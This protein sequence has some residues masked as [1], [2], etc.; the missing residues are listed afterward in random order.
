MTR[1]GRI[2]IWIVVAIAVLL[3]AIVL[4]VALFN[5]N[6]ARPW[7]ASDFASKQSARVSSNCPTAGRSAASSNGVTAFSP[8]SNSNCCNFRRGM[9]AAARDDVARC[10]GLDTAQRFRNRMRSGHYPKGY[11]NARTNDKTASEALLQHVG[12]S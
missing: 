1:A 9:R 12:T 4:F 5:W 11:T 8:G 6:N 10:V 3:V 7:R 2:L